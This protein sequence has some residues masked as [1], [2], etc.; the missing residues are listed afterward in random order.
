VSI[1]ITGD[2]FCYATNV[3]YRLDTPQARA[4]LD[5]FVTLPQPKGFGMEE[6]RDLLY[7]SPRRRDGQPRARALSPGCRALA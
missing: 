5:D 3:D 4:F 6:P 7:P 1:T 2:L